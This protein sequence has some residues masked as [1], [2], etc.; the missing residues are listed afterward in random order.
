MANWSPH[1]VYFLQVIPRYVILCTACTPCQ[2]A[3][4]PWY[5]ILVS[6]NPTSRDFTPIKLSAAMWVTKFS[7]KDNIYLGS[8]INDICQWTFGPIWTYNCGFIKQRLGKMAKKN[9]GQGRREDSFDC[10][11]TQLQ[12]RLIFSIQMIVSDKRLVILSRICWSPIF[13]T[14]TAY[15]NDFRHVTWSFAF[16]THPFQQTHNVTR[17]YDPYICY[18]Q[19]FN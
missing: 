5:G 7:K 8:K 6:W 18:V 13:K 4:A 3:C 12:R 15:S 19:W 2:E 17:S 16:S 11:P 9:T 14:K 1:I 10:M